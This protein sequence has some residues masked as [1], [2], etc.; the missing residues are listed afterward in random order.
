MNNHITQQKRGLEEVSP[1]NEESSSWGDIGLIS[2]LGTQMVMI[3]MMNMMA[4]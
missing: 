3:F 4:R 2:E 1:Q